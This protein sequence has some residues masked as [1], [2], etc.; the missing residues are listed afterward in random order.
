M[1]F[2][3]FLSYYFINTPNNPPGRAQLYKLASQDDPLAVAFLNR[4]SP[5]DFGYTM[6]KDYLDFTIRNDFDIQKLEGLDWEIENIVESSLSKTAA[7]SSDT[8]IPKLLQRFTLQK[9]LAND[10]WFDST[11]EPERVVEDAFSM[12]PPSDEQLHRTNPKRYDKRHDW[13]DSTNDSGHSGEYSNRYDNAIP[14]EASLK[15]SSDVIDPTFD[16]YKQKNQD[17][18]NRRFQ[19][20]DQEGYDIF[21]RGKEAQT[22]RFKTL[23]SLGSYGQDKSLPELYQG[24]SILDIGAG[25]GDLADY[26]KQQNVD[27]SKYVGIDIVPK[28]VDIAKQKH[29]DLN[30]ELKD[31]QKDPYPENSFDYVFG[32]GLFALSHENWDQYVTDMLRIMLNTAKSVVGVNFITNSTGSAE[33]HSTFKNEIIEL[34]SAIMQNPFDIIEGYQQ[35]DYTLFLYK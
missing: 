26:L 7:I 20:V 22:Q 25:Y 31:I 11:P 2:S 8:L 23:V 5:P 19:G 18:F 1:T 15:F 12:N 16:D 3:R 9:K 33:F 34:A 21:W 35:D 24:K 13:Y 14:L 6:Y 28:I 32:C 27:I 29:P 30:I 17:I 10:A 4:V